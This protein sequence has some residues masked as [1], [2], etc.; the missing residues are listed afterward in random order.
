M[1]HRSAR[2]W[3]GNYILP[4]Q[5]EVRIVELCY[6]IDLVGA[7]WHTDTA[8]RTAIRPYL[9]L[10]ILSPSPVDISEPESHAI[11]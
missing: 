5:L 6:Y 2:N 9:Q 8:R 11:T 10:I 7:L 1:H 4:G 3:N